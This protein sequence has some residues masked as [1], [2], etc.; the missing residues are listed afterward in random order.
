MRR[1]TRSRQNQSPPS[2]PRRK[3]SPREQWEQEMVRKLGLEDVEWDPQESCSCCAAEREAQAEEAREEAALKAREAA[4]KALDEAL[5][6]QAREELEQEE[7]EAEEL[8]ELD[9]EEDD[10]DWDD[11]PM[12]LRGEALQRATRILH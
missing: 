3:L 2:G 5:M 9:L 11:E 10:E 1:P 4:A 12:S 6:Q 7:R 8:E